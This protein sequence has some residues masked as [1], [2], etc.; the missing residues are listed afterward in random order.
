[1]D[2]DTTTAAPTGGPVD[3]GTYDVLRQ[4]ARRPGRRAGAPGR[5]AEHPPHR[6]V[7]LDRAPAH[8]HRADPHRT[9][10]RPPR[11]GGRRRAAA[12][13][14]R[15]RPGGTG[16]GRG[17]R[18]TRPVRTGDGGAGPG[19]ADR[20]R[21]LRTRVHRAAPLLPR[22]PASAAAPGGREAARRLP[23][24]R[25][26]G[27]HQGA[28]LGARPGRLTG[29]VPRRARRPRPRLPA[30]A[31]L[32]LDRRLPRVARTG[33]A[34]AHRGGR[35]RPGQRRALRRHPRRH[36]HRQDGQRHRHP[37]RD[38]PGAGRRAPPVAGRRGGRARHDRAAGPAPGTPVQRGVLAV[39]G[40]Q[41]TAR[42]RAAARRHRAGP[43]TGCRRTRESSSPAATTSPPA[44][45]RPSTSPS[46]SPTRSSRARSAPRTARTSS[47]S[48]A[49]PTTAGACCCPTT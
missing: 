21:G 34:S 7:R 36:P 6:G 38:L 28:A 9:A 37:G 13:R 42:H 10:G 25:E 12:V 39:P 30:L 15:T 49:P 11:P 3:A 45:P 4:P 47:T 41:H 40:L 2:T 29:R 22:R 14:L 48:S 31:R 20:R 1:M 24:R 46:R 32:H 16:P 26:R 35:G 27:R 5:G 23:Y 43:A 8:R 19:R 17:G 44:P 33:A 18:R